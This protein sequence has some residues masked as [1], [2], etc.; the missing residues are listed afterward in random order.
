MGFLLDQKARRR[1]AAAQRIERRRL[2][3]AALEGMG[4]TRVE[5]TPRGGRQRRRHVPLK[6]D[7]LLPVLRIGHRHGRQQGLGVRVAGVAVQL[8]GL[9]Q[10]H[11]L[12]QVHHRH[13]RGDVLHDLQVM[14]DEE[15]GELQL[16]LQ[17]HQEV[18][19]LRLDGHVEG[20]DGLVR[21]DQIGPQSDGASNA[22]ALTLAPGKLMGIAVHRVARQPHQIHQREH[23]LFALP[24]LGQS[25]DGERLANEVSN[26]QPG[27]QRGVGILE[28][29]L[30]APAKGTQPSGLQACQLLPLEADGTGRW[31]DEP[32]QG[33]PQGALA[34]A[35][36]PH[37]SE[38][39][40]AH[41]IEAHAVHGLHRAANAPQQPSA[42]REV[43]L[44]VPYLEQGLTHGA[45]TGL[46][47]AA[48]WPSRLSSRRGSTWA[49]TSSARSHRSRKRQPPGRR[50]RLGTMPGMALNRLRSP[51]ASTSWKEGMERNRPAVYGWAG[52]AKRAFTGA[53]STT[54]PAYITTTASQLSATTPRSWVMSITAIPRSAWSRLSRSRICAWIV[55]SSAVVGSS[56]MSSC[57]PH[58][59]AMAIITRWRMPPESWWG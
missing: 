27:V 32:Q 42:H 8:R 13:P 43:R 16:P 9:R 26:R 58:A 23:L 25:V 24:A 7:A 46:W 6:Q 40:T 18:D 57:G 28:D 41:H 31:L 44:H 56:A 51:P 45:G 53:C 35:A 39:L 10:L 3:A 20:A 55:T 21:D 4:A 19:D 2:A 48:D 50:R 47:H 11:D 30:H 1:V 15:V 33:T 59:R 49:Q 22:D 12:P 34:T 29:E 14:R 52:R 38:R 36:L 17:V 5:R 37:Q 54:R